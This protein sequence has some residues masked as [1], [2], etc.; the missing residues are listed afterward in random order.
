MKVAFR[1]DASNEIG[2]GHVIR[3]I[4]LARIFKERGA[5]IQFIC[6]SHEGHLSGLIKKNNFNIKLLSQSYTINKKK[7]S[8]N[9]Y[10]NFFL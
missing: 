7:G 10:S 9:N 5:N 1:V 2:T 8:K 3:C 4:T 6:R